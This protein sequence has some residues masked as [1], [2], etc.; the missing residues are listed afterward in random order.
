MTVVV[1][2]QSV[3]H[4]RYADM[5]GVVGFEP[6]CLAATDFKSVVSAIPP[7]PRTYSIVNS[8]YTIQCLHS[9]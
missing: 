1:A 2:Q 9:T 8:Y 4:L 7:H 3:C 5:V 6:T